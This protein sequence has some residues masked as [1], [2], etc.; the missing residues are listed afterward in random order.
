MSTLSWALGGAL[1]IALPIVYAKLNDR[2][3]SS[4]PERA[5]A[6]SPS[7]ATPESVR[8]LAKKL[9]ENPISIDDQIPPKTGRRYVVVGGVCHP[10]TF[11]F[12]LHYS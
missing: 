8:A 9:E 12:L 3:L 10:F 2:I 6:F 11:S 1:I 7:R 5:L 4:I